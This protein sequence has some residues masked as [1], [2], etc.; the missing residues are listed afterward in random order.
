MPIVHQDAL[1]LFDDTGQT[2]LAMAATLLN[3]G[4]VVGQQEPAETAQTE[5]NSSSA[6]T[7]SL[8]VSFLQLY[9]SWGMQAS[10]DLSV[11]G[12]N[13]TTNSLPVHPQFIGLWSHGPL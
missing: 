3:L 7:P 4:V 9:R 6:K 10:Q 11:A 1:H 8:P 5:S 12:V 13:L 2:L